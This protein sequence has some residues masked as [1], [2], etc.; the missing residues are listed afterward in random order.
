LAKHILYNASVTLN[1]V[2]LSDHV[3][4]VE[5]S[6]SINSQNAAAMSDVEDYSM[7]GTRTLGDITI[8]MYQDYASGKVWQTLNG[9]WTNRTSFTAV[10]KADS[11][12]AA[13]TNPSLSVS[14][15]IKSMSAISGSRGDRHMSK[16]VLAPAAAMAIT[17][18]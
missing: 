13:T 9:L 12:S 8:N 5:Y 15:F 14:V 16:I 7:A 3:D 6:L 4:S 1:S 10:I 11:A 18:P 2:D 17:Q